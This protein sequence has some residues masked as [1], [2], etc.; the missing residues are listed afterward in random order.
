MCFFSESSTS[1]STD[2]ESSTSKGYR[3]IKVGH[4]N[5]RSL[6]NRTYLSLVKETVFL[7]K[8]DIFTISGS[9]LEKPFR[10]LNSIFLAIA[11]TDKIV[12]KL[13]VVVYV[14]LLGTVYKYYRYLISH[15]FARDYNNFGCRD[16]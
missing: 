14:F 8:L 5:V 6:K 13:R 10:M 3:K 2:S 7:H 16:N 12:Y 1:T 9:W 15:Q 11:F 4:L